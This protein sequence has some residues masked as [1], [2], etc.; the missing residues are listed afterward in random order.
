MTEEIV[1]IVTVFLFTMLK[2][3][4]GPTMGYAFK[5]NIV[6]TILVTIGGMMASVVLFTFF[7]A[8]NILGISC[9]YRY[10]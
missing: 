4:F 10:M 5:F 3:F 7:G 1:K 2:V 9:L 6:T 8:I